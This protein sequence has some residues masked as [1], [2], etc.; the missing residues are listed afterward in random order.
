M[1]CGEKIDL[2][3]FFRK[4]G[5]QKVRYLEIYLIGAYILFLSPIKHEYE[6]YR[7]KTGNF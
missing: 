5:A 4:Q 2:Y 1:S 7:S 3:F 6:A